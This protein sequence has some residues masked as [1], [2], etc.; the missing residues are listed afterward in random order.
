MNTNLTNSIEH[1]EFHSK[2]GMIILLSSLTMLFIALFASYGILRARS[3]VWKYNTIDL[4]SLIFLWSN[5]GI[6][7]FSSITYHIMSQNKI[8]KKKWRT[9]RRYKHVLKWLN[10]TLATGLLFL[11]SQI[12]LWFNLYSTGYRITSHQISSFFYLFSGLHGL[13]IVG[14]LIS[15]IWLKN[16]IR[17]SNRYTNQI[18]LVG[19]FWHFLTVVWLIIFSLIIMH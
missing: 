11:I 12:L 13:H 5:T 3:N 6:L 19:M 1:K 14:G 9:R 4:S 2:L 18:Q 10:I 8:Q 17:A 15:L 7:I 16:T